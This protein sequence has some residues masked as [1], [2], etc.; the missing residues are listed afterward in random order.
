MA[1]ALSNTA[2][3]ENGNSFYV[4]RG[5]AF[6]NEYARVDPISKQRYDGGP[7]NANHLLGSFPTLFPYGLGGFEVGRPLNVPYELHARWA[8]RYG[9]K[10]FRLNHQFVF[11]I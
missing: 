8:L 4:R 1:H 3:E 10:R 7:S 9:D 2:S 5:S 11:Q 6:I